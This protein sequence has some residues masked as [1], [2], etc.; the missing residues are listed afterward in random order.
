MFESKE[1]IKFMIAKIFFTLAE[2]KFEEINSIRPPKY[3]GK[4]TFEL[5]YI[6]EGFGNLVI[7]EKTYDIKKGSIIGIPEFTSYSIIPNGSL[8]VYSIYFLIDTKTGYKEFL[9]L[10]HKT[11]VLEDKYDIYHEFYIL[12]NELQTKKLGYN[13]IVTSSFKI[14]VIKTIRNANITGKRVSYWPIENLQFE[15]EKI[16]Y[17]EFSTITVIDLAKRLNMSVRELQRY[18]DKNYNKN[19]SELKKNYKL[20]YA[21]NRLTYSDASIDQISQEL[22]F[23]TRE[24]FCFFFKKELDMTP[25]NY[26][27]KTKLLTLKREKNE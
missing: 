12:I 3:H 10:L 23:T 27:K 13:E 5:I 7:N 24:H 9:P 25:S 1:S 18:L 17:N 26:R 16:L 2:F 20:E 4:D 11:Y 14:I 6:D 8:K 22:N 19:F 21:K 15:I